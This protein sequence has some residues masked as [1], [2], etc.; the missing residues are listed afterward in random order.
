MYVDTQGGYV[1]KLEFVAVFDITKWMALSRS[2]QKF[3]VRALFPD[4]RINTTVDYD[5]KGPAVGL[6][7]YF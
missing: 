1:Q 2:Y 3:F 4:D 7:L 6:N 5:F